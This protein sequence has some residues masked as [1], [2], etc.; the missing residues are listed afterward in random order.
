MR[1]MLVVTMAGALSLACAHPA[2]QARAPAEGEPT[3]KVMTYNVNFGLPGEPTAVEAIRHAAADLVLLQE[4]TPLWEAMLRQELRRQYP[5]MAFRHCCG[6]GGLGIL[7]KRPFK[8]LDYLPPPEGGWFPAWRVL[9]S[10]ALGPVQVL[11]VHLRPP[12]SET[13]GGV[14]GHPRPGGVRQRQIASEWAHLDPALP[15]LVAG[16]FNESSSGSAVGFLRSKGLTSV[17]PEFDQGRATWRWPTSVGTIHLELDHIFHDPRLE[18]I[19]ARALEEGQ[20]DH[21]PVVA[22]FTRR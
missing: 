20:S 6:A 2:R 7:S 17:L 10:T 18:P 1:P 15:T 14:S 5:H 8:E 11:N 9:L 19:D 3:L 21:L 13:G 4:T 22:T 16:D 12:L